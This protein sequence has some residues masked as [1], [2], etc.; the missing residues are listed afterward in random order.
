MGA[1]MK[2]DSY[3]RVTLELL[4]Q[5]SGRPLPTPPREILEALARVFG[6][7]VLD[8]RRRVPQP[9]VIE[10]DRAH[11]AVL[12]AMILDQIKKEGDGSPKRGTGRATPQPPPSAPRLP[13][14][15][16]DTP[17]PSP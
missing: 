1:R 12:L 4:P 6:P 15:L 9:L 3:S 7:A 10:L 13:L 14:T 5:G 16:L 17:P 2:C 8:P 11:T